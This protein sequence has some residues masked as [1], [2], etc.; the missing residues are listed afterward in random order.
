VHSEK[1]IC[2]TPLQVSYIEEDKTQILQTCF[3]YNFLKLIFRL[4]LNG[5]EISLKFWVVMIPIFKFC[6]EK[7]EGHICTFFE[8]LKPNSQETP[9]NFEIRVFQKGFRTIFYT[10]IPVNPY[11]FL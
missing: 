7:R 8:T 10:Y 1:V 2:Q 4:F 5:F 3:A 11:H 9:Q 6:D